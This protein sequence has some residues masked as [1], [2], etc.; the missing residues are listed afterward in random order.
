MSKEVKV[1]VPDIGDFTDV[2]IVEVLVSVGERIQAEQSL[3]TLESDKATM[4]VPSPVAGTIS[5]L[6]VGL[7]DTVS[8]GDVVA[9]IDADEAAEE[10]PSEQPE[11]EPA[12]AEAAPAAEPVK[13]KPVSPAPAAATPPPP[14]GSRRSSQ[15]S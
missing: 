1:H 10:A 11:P 13:P 14:V 6:K 15:A 2:P 9:V 5:E 7:G 12:A 3:V 4:E 8:E